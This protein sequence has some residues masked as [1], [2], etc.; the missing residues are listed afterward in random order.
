M[1]KKVRQQQLHFNQRV[2]TR[3]TYPINRKVI[4]DAIVKGNGIHI[5]KQ[6]NRVS[7]WAVR[8]EN[9]L[10]IFVYDKITKNPVTVLPKESEYYDYLKSKIFVLSLRD[11]SQWCNECG[12][13]LALGSTLQCRCCINE[14]CTDCKNSHYISCVILNNGWKTLSQSKKISKG[15]DE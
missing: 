1:V 14:I 6:S 5:I 9:E 7:L 15:D 12:K 3:L 4:V 8:V 2:S 11:D 13:P 10:P